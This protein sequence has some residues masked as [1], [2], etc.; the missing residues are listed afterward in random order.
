MAI[1]VKNGV[2][3]YDVETVLNDTNAAAVSGS[4]EVAGKLGSQAQV[5]DLG[6]PARTDGQLVILV[7]SNG[8]SANMKQTVKLQ[9]SSDN[10][11]SD[12]V[13]LVI[14]EFGNASALPGSKNIG[15]DKYVLPYTNV[16][17]DVA[18]QYL[19]TVASTSATSSDSIKYVAY[20]IP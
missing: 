16:Q 12:I 13:D 2:G 5:V 19:R 18:Y 8:V 6:A 20:L 11:E 1:Y 17:A 7:E 3:V 15:A 14:K 10:F 9:G 4:T